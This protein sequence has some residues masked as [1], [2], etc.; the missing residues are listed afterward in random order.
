MPFLYAVCST[1]TLLFIP[2]NLMVY[3]RS[4]LL[5]VPFCDVTFLGGS[6]CFLP[7]SFP[8][9]QPLPLLPPFLRSSWST[10]WSNP[11]NSLKVF[12]FF[13]IVGDG[14]F[15]I[16]GSR[17][18]RLFFCLFWRGLTPPQSPVLAFPWRGVR[19][20][21]LCRDL[22]AVYGLPVGPARCPLVSQT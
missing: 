8:W 10:L 14:C 9:C 6:G 18:N 20:G 13:S 3:H 1:V 21:F 11:V 4:L 12:L 5:E 17:Y 15:Y 16:T 19:S 7:L 2:N 22:D